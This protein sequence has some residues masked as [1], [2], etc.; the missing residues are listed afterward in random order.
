MTTTAGHEAAL[1]RDLSRMGYFLVSDV[2]ESDAYY[3][4]TQVSLGG[5]GLRL[6]TPDKFTLEQAEAWCA[7]ELANWRNAEAV[8]E[9]VDEALPTDEWL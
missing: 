8:A 4:I 5:A 6:E 9:A 3:V 7:T 2:G 1:A